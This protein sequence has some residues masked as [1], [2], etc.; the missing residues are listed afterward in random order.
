[1]TFAN[2]EPPH[3]DIKRCNTLNNWHV[4][5][6]EYGIVDTE[7]FQ[8][9]LLTFTI[10]IVNIQRPCEFVVYD[11]TDI[12]IWMDYIYIRSCNTEL[13]VSGLAHTKVKYMYKVFCLLDVYK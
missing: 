6:F 4:Q 5:Q 12:F 8:Q 7:R 3:Y 9:A 10:Y 13:F 2:A 11:R 1:M